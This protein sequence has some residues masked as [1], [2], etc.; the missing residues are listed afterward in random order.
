MEED[1]SLVLIFYLLCIHPE[2]LR[3]MIMIFIGL[4]YSIPAFN[5]VVNVTCYVTC[6]S[7]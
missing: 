2:A 1:Y 4:Q 3:T 7:S 5:D 6:E